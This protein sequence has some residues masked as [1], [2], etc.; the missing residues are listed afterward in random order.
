MSTATDQ[1]FD[2]GFATLPLMAILRGF[3][4]AR[5]VQLCERA[6]DLGITLVEVP[7][8]SDE[9][10]EALRQAVRERCWARR[11]RRSGHRD[12]GAASGRRRRGGRGVHRRSGVLPAGGT[13]VS[14]GG[15]AASA[16]RR[17]RV[18]DPAGAGVGTCRGSRPFRHQSSGWAGSPQCGGHFPRR[19]WSPPAG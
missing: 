18:G 11:D 1:L 13:S 2:A 5:T 8:Q 9:S 6:W 17:H 4:P 3:E 16:G 14:G 12:V 19:V 10:L 7:V 15:Y